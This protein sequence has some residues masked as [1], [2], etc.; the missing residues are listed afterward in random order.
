MPLTFTEA[1]Q[2]DQPGVDDVHVASAGGTGK[3]VKR[4]TARTFAEVVSGAVAKVQKAP[5]YVSRKVTNAQDII[6]WA[7]GQGFS[8]TTPA[9]EMHATVLYSKQP[10]DWNAA[11]DHADTVQVAATPSARAVEPL[12]DEGATVLRFASKDLTDRHQQFRDAGGSHDYDSYKPHVTISY[13]GAPA[14]MS[15]VEPYAGPINFGP[16]QYRLIDSGWSDNL[17]EKIGM[18]ISIEKVDEDRRQMFGWASVIEKD[19]VPI[20]DHQG[21][22]IDEGELEPAAYDFVVKSREGDDMHVGAPVSHLIESMV[23]TKEKQAALGIDLGKVG[24]WTGW[25]VDDPGVWAAHKRGERN[26][27]SIGGSAIREAM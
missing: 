26:E 7:K 22:V 11:G 18:R 14:D 5:L 25:Q 19:G 20:E 17:V 27:L 12:G 1:L 21:D 16:E 13:Q 6:D 9:S 4:K 24:W 8:T 23:F 3:P 15:T 2:K 10:M